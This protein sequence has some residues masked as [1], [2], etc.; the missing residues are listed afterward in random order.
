M[1]ERRLLV[2]LLGVLSVVAGLLTAGLAQPQTAHAV[3]VL[4][5]SPTHDATIQ[6]NSPD[7]NFGSDSTVV[8]DGT[9]EEAFLI[10][11]DVSGIGAVPILQAVLVLHVVDSSDHGG[12]FYLTSTSGWDETTVTWNTAPA[13]IGSPVATL[14]SV[15]TG[16]TYNVDL[17]GTLTGDGPIALRVTSPSANGADYGSKEHADVALRPTLAV[18]IDSGNT[19]PVAQDD[20]APVNAAGTASIDVLANDSDID[21][22][23]VP[24]SVAIVQQ[25]TGSAV[26]DPVTG[27]VVYTP[28]PAF[29][30]DDTFTY[31]VDDDLGATSNAATV[32][33][34][35]LPAPAPGETVVVA[36][37]DIACE[38]GDPITSRRCH[39]AATA[40]LAEALDPSAVLTLG[41]H[42]YEEGELP[43]FLASYDPTWGV[44]KGITFPSAGNH[45]YKTPGA[46]G[47]FDY[48]GAQA[49][50]SQAG[51]YSF[52]LGGWHMIVLNTTCQAVPGGCGPGS[53]QALWLEADLAQHSTTPCTI[54]Y[55]H[56]PRFASG[57]ASHDD[58]PELQELWRL[59]SANGA[60]LYLAGHNHN[61]QR[62]APLN[63]LGLEHPDGIRQFVI[64]TGGRSTTSVPPGELDPEV[65]S[66][67]VAFGVMRI[68]LGAGTYSWSFI[69]EPGDP[70]TDTGTA[71]CTDGAPSSP[72]DAVDDASATTIG[73]TAVVDVLA[74]DT[75]PDGD[76]LQVI[77]VDTTGT[78]GSVVNNGNGTVTYTPPAAFAGVDT[79]AY[80]A[81]DT[82]GLT[83]SATVTMTVGETVV[84]TLTPTDDA[85]VKE[86]SP[87]LG[88]GFDPTLEVDES[89]NKDFLLRFDASAIGTSTVADATLRLYNTNPSS[90]GGDFHAVTDS[91]WSQKTVTWNNAPAGAAAWSA[92]SAPWWRTRGT[93][94][95]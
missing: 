69:T 31:T 29:L 28:A 19:P 34:R 42:Q 71:P 55:G 23:L 36:A 46:Q 73:T 3:E 62:Y 38:P 33:V 76:P 25:G 39:H 58:N 51:Y 22:T 53:P 6:A 80:T 41:D 89:P 91:A 94:W 78:Q 44:L 60:D 83:D 66:L 45:E 95:T 79:F 61:M 70:S 57:N 82:A 47:Y 85:T 59:L 24:G 77:G 40:L 54:A 1:G 88:F 74:N 87:A 72:P 65:E 12:D 21:G 37:G 16:A 63:V 64:G 14:A 52:D 8:V 2:S 35:V 32:T 10:H 49:G 5:F 15:S 7:T 27:E 68:S 75:D 48:W 18:T 43:N 9:P 86:A 56:H 17:T 20:A 4:T 84:L 13:A 81:G 11:F 93:S 50:D 26:P 92:R 30:G 90:S 67:I